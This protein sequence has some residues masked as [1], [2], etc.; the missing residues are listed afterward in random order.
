MLCGVLSFFLSVCAVRIQKRQVA[1]NFAGVCIP[2]HK[3][4]VNKHCAKDIWC[5]MH[6]ESKWESVSKWATTCA[7]PFKANG[8]RVFCRSVSVI[9]WEWIS[10]G[11]FFKNG[12][13]NKHKNN[14]NVQYVTKTQQKFRYHTILPMKGN[15]IGDSTKE[16]CNS[17]VAYFEGSAVVLGKYSTV[18]WKYR[19]LPCKKYSRVLQ[20]YQECISAIHWK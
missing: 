19:A 7:D 15:G 17:T 18:L 11:D 20:R 13:L 5:K 9:V 10:L 8:W 6:I 2:G 1:R 12:V 4:S 16:Y 14:A 3:V